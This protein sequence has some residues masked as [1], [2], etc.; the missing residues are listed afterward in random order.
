MFLAMTLINVLRALMTSLGPN[1]FWS[2]PQAVIPVPRML[3]AM[4]T[5]AATRAR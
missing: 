5:A 1:D 2:W 4:H 3:A